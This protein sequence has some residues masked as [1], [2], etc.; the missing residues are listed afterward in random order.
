MRGLAYFKEKQEG[1][2]LVVQVCQHI[3]NINTNLRYISYRHVYKYFPYHIVYIR[4]YV[5]WDLV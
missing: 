1:M 4:T 5:M 2:W 3:L